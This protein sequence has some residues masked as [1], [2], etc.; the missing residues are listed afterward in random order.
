MLGRISLNPDLN[1]FNLESNRILRSKTPSI[2]M[3]EDVPTAKPIKEYFTP[4]AYTSA[5]C[6]LIP[7]T[8]V[9]HYEIKSSVI[10]LLPSFYELTNEDPYN[11]LDKFLKVCSTVKIQNFSDDALRL[12][13]F[14]FTPK[15]K[16]KH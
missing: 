13:L 10:Q 15:D 9:N 8:G 2:T 14:P 11:H 16:V 1:P 5:S 4:Y 12:T 6:I 3:V 7:N